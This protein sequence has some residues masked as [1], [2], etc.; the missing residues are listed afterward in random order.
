MGILRVDTWGFYADITRIFYD[1]IKINL[2]N[3]CQ[4]ATHSERKYV[5]GSTQ[6]ST[7]LQSAL[8]TGE[9][10]THLL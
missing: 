4:F 3:I 1:R 9:N 10:V 2:V 7:S 6:H 8:Y 5:L